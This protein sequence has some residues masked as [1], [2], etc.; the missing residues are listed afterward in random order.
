[1]KR[2]NRKD[3]INK[4]TKIQLIADQEIYILTF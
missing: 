3:Y 2:L 1:M 4:A